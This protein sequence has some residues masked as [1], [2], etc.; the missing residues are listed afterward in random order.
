M[1]FENTPRPYESVCLTSV[2]AISSPLLKISKNFEFNSAI[3]PASVWKEYSIKSQ[4]KQV[5]SNSSLSVR[6]LYE[7]RLIAK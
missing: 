6:F 7:F 1:Y 3:I 2:V 5:A 4:K